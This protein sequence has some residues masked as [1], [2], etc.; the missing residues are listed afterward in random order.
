MAT[1]HKQT[2][3]IHLHMHI[4]YVNEDLHTRDN[5]ETGDHAATSPVPPPLAPLARAQCS[6]LSVSEC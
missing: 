6:L 5:T 1:K 2:V 3:H 4:I